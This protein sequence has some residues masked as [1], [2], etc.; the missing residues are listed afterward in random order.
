M[1]PVYAFNSL[2]HMMPLAIGFEALLLQKG[3]WQNLLPGR[4]GSLEVNEGIIKFLKMA[5]FSLQFHL[6]QLTWAAR[7]NDEKQ[8][9]L[10]FF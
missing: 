10:W 6:L 5:A 8:K 1:L 4:G 7:S 9:S 3:D 2:G